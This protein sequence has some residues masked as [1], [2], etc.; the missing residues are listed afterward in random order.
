MII[1]FR[2]S[3]L[4]SVESY[5]TDVFQLFAFNI[6]ELKQTRRRRLTGTSQNERFN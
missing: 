2:V 5:I 3:Q 6:R 1:S 4:L